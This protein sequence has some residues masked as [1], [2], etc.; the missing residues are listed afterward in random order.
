RADGAVAPAPRARDAAPGAKATLRV[1]YVIGYPQRMAGAPRSL[2]ELVRHLPPHV[3]PHVL[4]MGEGPV[5]AAFREA[6]L[7]VTVIAPEGALGSHGG[8]LFRTS[9]LQRARIAAGEL[10]PITRKVHR[11]LRELRIGLVHVNEARAA[12]MTVPAARMLGLPVIA[13]LRGEM[14]LRKAGR[15]LFEASADRIITV[16]DGVQDTLSAGGRRKAVTV[17]NGTRVPSTTQAPPAWPAGLRARGRLVVCC[18]ASVVPFKGHHHLIRAVAELNR[19]GWGDRAV[20]LAVGDFP[21]GSSD[22]QAW[23]FD[24]CRELGV[25]NLTFT[26]WQGD[27]FPFYHLADVT[28]LPSVS[29]EQLEMPGRTLQ[30]RG[31]EGFPRTHLEAMALGLPV[32]GTRIAGVPEQIVDGETGLLVPPSDPAAL[33]DALETL[34]ASEPLRRRMGSAARDR[35]LELFSTAAYVAG[36]CREYD[37]VLDGRR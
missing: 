13:H 37:R 28:V 9:L 6:G 29:Q 11:L 35:A 24:L 26:G 20:F 34:L 19:R 7:P 16:S 1:L 10:L 22:Y 21:E 27:P 30:V 33:A 36:V 17:Y 4:V 8:A 25:D 18:F 3:E 5:A 32:I 31:S 12:L 23:L 2:L 14:P 15:F